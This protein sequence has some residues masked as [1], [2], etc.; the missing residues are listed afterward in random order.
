[1]NQEGNSSAARV[2]ERFSLYTNKPI[3]TLKFNSSGSLLL[4]VA[5]SDSKVY[6]ID[7]RMNAGAR[8]S[9]TLV[10]VHGQRLHTTYQL[11][12]GHQKQYE[13]G[14]YVLGYTHVLDE[15]NAA[16]NTEIVCLDCFDYVSSVGG[17][18]GISTRIVAGIHDPS[19]WD[20]QIR[21][22]IQQE[23]LL[24]ADSPANKAVIAA[25][26]GAVSLATA[27]LV[28][29]PNTNLGHHNV[30]VGCAN[31]EPLIPLS[32]NPNQTYYTA[33]LDYCNYNNNNN[34]TSNNSERGVQHQKL[35]TKLV[36]F[37]FSYHMYAAAAA[38]AQQASNSHDSIY[39]S[40]S[41]FDFRDEALNKCTLLSHYLFS[42]CVLTARNQVCAY[43]DGYLCKLTLPDTLAQQQA[44]T[45][46]GAVAVQQQQQQQ[47]QGKANNALYLE[48]NEIVGVCDYGYG[49][50]VRTPLNASFVASAGVDGSLSVRTCQDLKA[51]V[52]ARAAHYINGG[53]KHLAWNLLPNESGLGSMSLLVL[54]HDG[55]ISCVNWK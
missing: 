7:T 55:I 27:G 18:R 8:A 9:S 37:E 25:S 3:K 32:P 20:Q 40:L 19:V 31:E 16:N 54:G 24:V 11:N 1:V 15:S 22:Q 47:Q 49:L 34:K 30:L 45:A 2:I 43:V 13:P 14:F 21:K 26:A 52:E 5:E 23:I 29:T 38:A 4:T 39:V 41:K 48:L 51:F 10:D 12:G 28:T 6:L 36:A 53:V 17:S 50:L 44:N 42:D 35:A 46:A 33:E